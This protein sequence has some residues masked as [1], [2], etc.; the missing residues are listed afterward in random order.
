MGCSRQRAIKR[1]LRSAVHRNLRLLSQLKQLAQTLMP[2]PFGNRDLS[3]SLAAGAQSFKHADQ[4][5]DLVCAACLTGIVAALL[6][7]RRVAKFV[8]APE[9]FRSACLSHFDRCSF[10]RRSESDRAFASTL[11]TAFRYSAPSHF[12]CCIFPAALGATRSTRFA[13]QRARLTPK[14]F[15]PS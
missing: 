15:A 8:F 6:T 4:T 3:K 7:T 13:V 11:R 5:A 14:P 2:D 12:R 10:R 1:Q 9:M